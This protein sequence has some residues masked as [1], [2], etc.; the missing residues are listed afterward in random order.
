MV[1]VENM[2][3]NPK[4]IKHIFNSHK[5]ISR[6][7]ANAMTE[8]ELDFWFTEISKRLGWD[9]L[10]Q[11]RLEQRKSGFKKSLYHSVRGKVLAF[12]DAQRASDWIKKQRD[13]QI[14]DLTNKMK[15]AEEQIKSK[16]KTK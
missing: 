16:F 12:S 10:P 4:L 11:D 3:F 7:E 6:E 9:S 8:K 2:S 5:G 13:V 14:N 15:L 1:G